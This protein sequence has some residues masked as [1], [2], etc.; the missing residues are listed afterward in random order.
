MHFGQAAT[1]RAHRQ[2]VLATAYAAHPERFVKGR[3]QPADLPHAVWINP[4]A[5]KTAAQDGPGT[6]IV[7]SDDVR[8]D[9][10]RDT[11]EPFAVLPIDRSATLI[12]TTLVSQCH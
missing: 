5:K 2:Q 4:P 12:T 9:L 10:I 7:I 6:T 1:V 8:V 3:P 11:D